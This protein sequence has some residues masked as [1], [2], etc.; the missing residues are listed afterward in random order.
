MA[1]DPDAHE[2]S[3]AEF[4]LMRRKPGRVVVVAAVEIHRV[5]SLA[6]IAAEK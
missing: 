4:A 5:F 2:V 6:L 3:D 1:A